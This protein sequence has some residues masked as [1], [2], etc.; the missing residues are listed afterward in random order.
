MKRFKLRIGPWDR[1]ACNLG[2]DSALRQGAA[3]FF[4]E[5]FFRRKKVRFL[6]EIEKLTGASLIARRDENYAVVGRDLRLAEL[7]RRERL[8]NF[9]RLLA[10][11]RGVQRKRVGGNKGGVLRI[12]FVNFAGGFLAAIGIQIQEERELR[13][14]ILHVRVVRV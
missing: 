5:R 1:F 10:V 12:F 14:I 3:R 8:E 4:D 9:L 13:E 11:A 2:Q 7:F 6:A